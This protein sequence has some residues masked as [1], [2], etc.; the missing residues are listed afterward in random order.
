MEGV[1]VRVHWVGV[2]GAG[3]V[4]QS[5]AVEGMQPRMEGERVRPLLAWEA[6][7]G[8]VGLSLAVE[9]MQPRME[10]GRLLVGVV[11][12]I[13]VVVEVAARLV[14]PCSLDPWHRPPQRQGMMHA[15]CNVKGH[16]G[17]ISCRDSMYNM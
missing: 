8:R 4:G 10:G 7:A 11:H 6:G 2:A 9:G 3:R 14:T 17:H 16:I 5:P 12:L 1:R 13:A 15:H